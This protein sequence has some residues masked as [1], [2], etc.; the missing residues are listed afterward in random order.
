MRERVLITGGAGF[1]ASHLAASHLASGDEVH[2]LVRPGG[3]AHPERIQPDT[4]VHEVDLANL[5]QVRQCLGHANP[6]LVYHLATATGRDTTAPDPVECPAATRDLDQLMVLLAAA[7]ESPAIRA[8]VRSGSLA[9]Y[10]NQ[11]TPPR[12][13]RR[14]EPRT[15]YTAAMVAGT[16]YCA[17]VQPRLR[18][19]ILTAR[20]GLTYG[21]NQS[22][23]FL[24]PALLRHCFSG[25]TFIVN[26]PDHRRDMVFVDDIVAALRAMACSGL[27]GGTILNLASGR[28]RTV[29]EI[30]EIVLDVIGAPADRVR[31]EP[32]NAPTAGVDALYGSPDR[33][34]LLLGWRARTPLA[35]GIARTARSFEEVVA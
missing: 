32:S 29:R 20:L 14:E 17:I 9:E 27:P 15:V 4:E 25:T 10:G 7:A 28:V 30:V 26:R 3:P 6:T 8:M 33:A 23:Q 19:G 12:E 21:P 22:E 1:I 2:L 11:P 35:E 18:F 5:K 16:H 31:F 24:L 34:A 13:T